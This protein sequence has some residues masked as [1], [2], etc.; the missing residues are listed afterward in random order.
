MPSPARRL[1]L[2]SGILVTL[3]F[4]AGFARAADT[5]F[6]E[7]EK[8]RYL[9]TAGDC[10]AC[11]TTSKGAYLSG[12]LPIK[13]PFGLIYSPNITPDRDT[14]IGNWS[15]DEFYNAIHHGVRPDGKRLYPA[16]P[17]PYF[18]KLTRDD[19]DAIYAYL[20][21]VKAVSAKTQAPELTWP[22]NYR[23]VMRGWDWMFFKPGTYKANS[24]KSAEWNRGAYLVE[25]AAHCGACHT[26]KNIAGAA[27]TDE[28]LHGDRLQN[29]FAPNLASKGRASLAQWSVDDIVEY[30]QTGRNRHSGAT[31]L[32][33]EV[34]EKST[35]KLSRDDL[36]AMAVYLKDITSQP[37]PL[38]P[39]TPDPSV[40]ATGKRIFE[41][42]CAACHRK[43]GTGVPRM[44]PPL[45]KSALVHSRN[46]TTI[47]RMIL[48]GARTAAT[49]AAPTHSAMPA[50][51]WKLS[52]DEIA[53][54][55][56][57]VRNSWGNAAPSISPADVASLRKDLASRNQ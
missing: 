55:A 56:T 32:M 9:A 42:S 12:G 4:G 57:Y 2:S 10:T 45:A 20:K 50:Y 6:S 36:R 25:G 39:S 16:F 26:P 33:S 21:T 35:S 52:D 30:L 3:S 17:Y 14:G 51:D 13:T 24:A 47:I 54:V 5:S 40:M 23:I 15:K 34:V 22:L 19:V 37:A 8:G 48:K 41:T 38:S 43:D 11:H 18:T 49:N 28:K 7:I 44:F 31:G 46:P 1:L 29:W 53:A 27:K